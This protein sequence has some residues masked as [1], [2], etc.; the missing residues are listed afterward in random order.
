MSL[1]CQTETSMHYLRSVFL[2]LVILAGCGGG[3][4]ERVTP[5]ETAPRDEI[6]KILQTNCGQKAGWQ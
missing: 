2:G 1:E 5:P 4:G 6:R 3:G